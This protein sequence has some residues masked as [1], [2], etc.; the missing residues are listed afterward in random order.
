[1]LKHFVRI[2]ATL[3]LVLQFGAAAAASLV[4]G[5]DSGAAIGGYDPVAYFLDGKPTRGSAD[6]TTQ[7]NGA[8]WRFVSAEHRDKFVEMP[9][10]FAP[11]YGGYCAYATAHGSVAKGD[12]AQWKIV[13]GKL[14]LNNNWFAQK[15]WQADVPGN[16]EDSERKWPEVR[17][18]IEAKR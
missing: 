3:G 5:A 16:I 6:I 15:L 11:Q 8:T 1:M 7:W 10:K 2:A 13:D 4:S 9:E 12:G 18:K 17:T 14:Y